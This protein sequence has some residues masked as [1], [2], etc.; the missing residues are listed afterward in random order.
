MKYVATDEIRRNKVIIGTFLIQN[1]SI[2]QLKVI[3]RYKA[4]HYR[5]Y[6]F[7]IFMSCCKKCNPR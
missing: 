1:F 4:K 6:N 7:N 2:V 5:L 3:K